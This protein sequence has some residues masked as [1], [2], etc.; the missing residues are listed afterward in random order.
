MQKYIEEII[1]F[2]FAV[3]KNVLRLVVES[4]W[5]IRIRRLMPRTN[6]LMGFTLVETLVAVAILVAGIIGPLELISRSLHSAPFSKN[7][8]IAYNL[9]Q[10]GIELV[11]AIR[12]NNMLCDVNGGGR[13]WNSDP[14]GGLLNGYFEFSTEYPASFETISCS[15]YS[16]KTPR[17]IHRGLGTCN[18][19]LFIGGDGLYTYDPSG[20]PSLFSRC[21]QVCS[22]GGGCGASLDPDIPNTD[23]MDIVSTII[24]NE[25][26]RDKSVI[27]R[28][29]LYKLRCLD[30]S[31]NPC[32]G[33]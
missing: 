12:D 33:Y 13:T 27:L 7:N 4:H 2:G 11:R 9:A 21:V 14:G 24:W 23:Y 10:E 17:P 31:N 3:S 15:S 6:S 20:T 5:V 18:N 25:H 29:R 1:L 16:F 19:I 8:L 26:G 22:P 30:V 28:D 32:S